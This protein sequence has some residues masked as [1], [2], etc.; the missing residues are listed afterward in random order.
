M[1]KALEHRLDRVLD[2]P[3]PW[4]AWPTLLAVVG[5]GTVVA[6]WVFGPGPDHTVLFL[7]DPVQGTCAFLEGTGLPCPQCGMTRSWVHMARGHV[8]D[9][10]RYNPAGATL[11]LWLVTSGVVGAVRLVARDKRRLSPGD[12]LLAAWA[13]FW[14]AVVYALAYALRIGLG[15]NPIPGS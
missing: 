2:H 4:W 15:V 6:S 13:V 14:L 5:A 7:G 8:L 9:A 10:L 11:W 1:L 3:W 12:R